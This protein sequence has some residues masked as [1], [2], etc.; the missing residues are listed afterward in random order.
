MRR[1]S[2]P[3]NIHRTS[4]RLMEVPNSALILSRSGGVQVSTVNSYAPFSASTIHAANASAPP[5]PLKVVRIIN[6]RGR[7][8]TARESASRVGI[9]PIASG[10]VPAIVNKS[11]RYETLENHAAN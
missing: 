9:P 3:G 7:F 10:N 8:F 11:N 5:Y 1:A 4:S 6:P 2:G